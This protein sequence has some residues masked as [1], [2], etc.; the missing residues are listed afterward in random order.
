M[1][2]FITGGNGQL[3]K[4]LTLVLKQRGIDFKVST[5]KELDVRSPE[6]TLTFIKSVN[7]SVIVNTAAW[8]DVD[9]AE[10]NFDAVF[11]VNTLGAQ[12]LALAAKSINA[13]FVQISTD[14]VFSG[15][16]TGLWNELDMR[17]PATIYGK[18]KAAGEDAVLSSYSECSYL[19]RTAW[20]YS[21]FG[22]NFAKTMT[23]L[24]LNSEDEVRVVKD[25][26]GQP[27]SSLDLAIQII[28]T[29]ESQAPIG[30]YHATNSGEASW[31]EFAQEIFKLT[32]KDVSRVIPVATSEFPKLTN[33]P[34]NS[35]LSHDAWK[36]TSI[37]PMQNWRTALAE[38]MPSII[39]TVREAQ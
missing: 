5:S 15:E 31:F 7:P 4:S 30:I 1:T 28:D 23:G 13:L 39:S 25:Q 11:A 27:T 36:N 10:S 22:K 21:K 37:A 24:A 14:Y 38:A 18:S 2:W 3:G 35:V 8:T 6:Q 20:L 19:I 26:F 16:G 12:N 32:G 29:V 33:R 9:G 17:Y 34:A